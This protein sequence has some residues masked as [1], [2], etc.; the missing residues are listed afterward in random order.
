RGGGGGRARG[1]E[2][3]RCRPGRGGGG[4]RRAP[5]GADLLTASRER[6]A[7]GA[8]DGGS[9]RRVPGGVDV[10]RGD[11]VLTGVVVRPRGGSAAR[12]VSETVAGAGHPDAVAGVALHA[13]AVDLDRPEAAVIDP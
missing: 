8:E 12:V 2:P 11:V 6:R 10:P 4:G 1:P 7:V 3:G 5:P 13:V 9:A